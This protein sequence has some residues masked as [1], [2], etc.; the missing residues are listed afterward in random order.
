[1]PD[2][3]EDPQPIADEEPKPLKVED[4]VYLTGRPKRTIYEWIRNGTLASVPDPDDRRRRLVY[5]DEVVRIA[6]KNVR[7]EARTKT[8]KAVKLS[9][10]E[11]ID[12]IVP[13]GK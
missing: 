2:M 1:M 9:T 12:I 5:Y 10:G 6:R 3:P 8:V 7:G 13:L 11:T 4:V